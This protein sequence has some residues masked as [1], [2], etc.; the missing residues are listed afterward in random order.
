MSPET[1]GLV[2][3]Y[4]LVAKRLDV[5]ER[6]PRRRVG[7]RSASREDALVLN[8][9]RLHSYALLGPEDTWLW[10]HMDG[11]R[12]IKELIVA[13]FQE[14]RVIAPARVLQL[15]GMLEQRGMLAGDQIDIWTSLAARLH[16][17]SARLRDRGTR[18]WRRLTARGHLDR[19]RAASAAER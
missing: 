14:H 4:A 18:A 1:A 13:F 19:T 11:T 7:L 15:V 10:E 2:D 8:N 6:V 3:V 9:P 12:A 17:S 5:M 16:P